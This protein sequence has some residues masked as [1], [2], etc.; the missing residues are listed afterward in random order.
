M[1]LTVTPL[2]FLSGRIPAGARRD[3]VAE[4]EIRQ[5]EGSHDAE[6]RQGD[7]VKRDIVGFWS[8]RLGRHPP[9]IWEGV[10]ALPG[11]LLAIVGAALARRMR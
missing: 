5:H 8:R 1:A 10:L 3:E 9:G 7:G 4:G 11:V 2:I 6:P